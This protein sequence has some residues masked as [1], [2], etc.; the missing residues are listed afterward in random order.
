MATYNS[1]EDFLDDVENAISES[2][3]EAGEKVKEKMSQTIYR[4]VYA[5]YT[6]SMYQR[7]YQML[8]SPQIIN[9]TKDSITINIKD[10][11]YPSLLGGIDS[12]DTVIE[13]FSTGQIIAHGSSLKSNPPMINYRQAVPLSQEID[14]NLKEFD[15]FFYK[16][17]RAKGF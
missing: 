12:I 1:I 9:K 7:T 15:E 14:N 2:L 5:T 6:P 4:L 8:N 13:K 3:D 16:S 11:M 17:M 10:V